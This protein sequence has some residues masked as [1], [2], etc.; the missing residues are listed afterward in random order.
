MNSLGLCEN[1]NINC[2]TYNADNGLCTS[3]YAGF[4]LH[5]GKCSPSASPDSCSK[6][7][8]SGSCVQCGPGSYLSQGQCL[9]I[10]AQCANFDKT[11]L[12]CTACYSGYSILNGVCQISKVDSEDAVENCYAYDSQ[13]R[14]IKC[15][16]RYYLSANACLTV[17]VFC[18]T[19]DGNNGNCLSCYSSFKLLNGR[20]T[21]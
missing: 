7:D 16:D 5:N 2:N 11:S 18:R 12:T 9:T 13:S 15:F 20:C 19:Y 6:F 1:V 10:D 14:C 21:Q 8:N 17:S 3:C 4:A